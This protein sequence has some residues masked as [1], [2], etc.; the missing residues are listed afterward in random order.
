MANTR[1]DIEIAPL[2]DN[3]SKANREIERATY[4]RDEVGLWGGDG[5]MQRMIVA[6]D[7]AGKHYTQ[8]EEGNVNRSLV[9][10]YNMQPPF[11]HVRRQWPSPALDQ[12]PNR[13][14]TLGPWLAS[15]PYARIS[16]HDSDVRAEDDFKDG[17]WWNHI[18]NTHNFLIRLQNCQPID[19]AEILSILR[20]QTQDLAKAIYIPERVF[21][22][23]PATQAPRDAQSRALH[24]DAIADTFR[25][26]QSC[27]KRPSMILRGLYKRRFFAAMVEVDEGSGNWVSVIFDRVG[28]GGTSGKAHLYIFDPNANQRDVRASDVVLM[29]RQVLRDI[30]HPYDFVAY[31]L[32]LSTQ[33]DHWVIGYVSAFCLLQTLRGTTGQRIM[34]VFEDK[35]INGVLVVTPD[36]DL[37]PENPTPRQE[38][39]LWEVEGGNSELRFRDWCID[40]DRV[41]GTANLESSTNWVL[42]HLVGCAAMELGIANSQSFKPT[43]LSNIKFNLESLAKN[44]WST[45]KASAQNTIFGGFNPFIPLSQAERRFGSSALGPYLTPYAVDVAGRIHKNPLDRSRVRKWSGVPDEGQYTPEVLR[46]PHLERGRRKRLAQIAGGSLTNAVPP[47]SYQPSDGES[48]E[49][50]EAGDSSGNDSGSDDNGTSSGGGG[51]SDM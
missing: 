20:A 36:G 38:R 28:G 39:A 46:P 21:T 17:E 42:T 26:F 40:I 10:L 24:V 3:S 27:E 5:T 49:S 45:L 9:S 1:D 11:V 47:D 2:P 41:R 33:T 25:D 32:P 30:G 31:V 22:I 15:S 7:G 16:R 14:L 12:I 23:Y 29:W 43:P 51:D 4:R 18:V 34:S 50:S 44:D 19:G 8:E 35:R 48:T 6:L 13:L 37:Y